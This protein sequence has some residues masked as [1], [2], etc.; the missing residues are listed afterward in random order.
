MS[1]RSRGLLSSADF[2]CLLVA[3]V[4]LMSSTILAGCKQDEPVLGGSGEQTADDQSASANDTTVEAILI[5]ALTSADASAG[6]TDGALASAAAD[7]ADGEF[8]QACVTSV[9]D[10]N[11]VTYTLIEC[12]GSWGLLRVS[13]TVVG[14]YTRTPQGDVQAALSGT[15][16]TV[17]EG[18]GDWKATAVR[19]GTGDLRTL[20]V[21][22]D[23]KGYTAQN[24]A[25]SR[26]GAYT[27]VL[28][29]GQR[30]VGLD[31]DWNTK[32]GLIA[33]D[34][35]V[36]DFRVCKGSCPDDGG[37]VTWTSGMKNT[38]L[39]YDGSEVALWSNSD[40]ESGTLKLACGN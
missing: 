1:F 33:W 23:W 32:I 4:V 35:A 25:T 40:G 16:L 27:A 37:T 17:N 15:G 10:K 8:G 13:G 31:G 29:L 30:C 12:T 11:I 6:T 3:G 38:V 28:D 24:R 22:T 14:T 2:S 18:V 7:G 39:T 9:V 20:A 34:T 36:Q 26:K 19:S 21:N 5:Q